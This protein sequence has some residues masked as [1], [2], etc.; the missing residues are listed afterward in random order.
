MV[1]DSMRA[2]SHIIAEERDGHW[3]AW[4]SGQPQIACGGQWPTV[5]IQRLI[6]A[7]GGME[8]SEEEIVSVE[9]A[10]RDGHLEFLIPHRSRWR[11]PVVSIN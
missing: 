8:L 9:D 3:S 1:S 5:A 4:F 7:F 2:F 10:T 11:M 6:E